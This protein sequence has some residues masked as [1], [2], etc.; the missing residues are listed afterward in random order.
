MI[1]SCSPGFLVVLKKSK[2]VWNFRKNSLSL[3]IEIFNGMGIWAV[4]IKM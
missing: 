1:L 4:Y 2:N 3:G